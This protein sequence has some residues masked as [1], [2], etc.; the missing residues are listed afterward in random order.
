MEELQSVVSNVSGINL[1]EKLAEYTQSDWRILQPAWDWMRSHEHYV[2][3]PLF[4]VIMSVTYY[5]LCMLPWSIIDLY[6]Q[7]WWWIQKY[8]IQHHK[9]VTFKQVRNAMA[10]ILFN[11][12][13]F[14]LPLAVSQWVYVTPNK[15]PV[16]APAVWTI[17]WQCLASLAIFDIEYFLLH[18]AFHKIRFL[19][20][21]VHS[22]HH[23]Y[24]APS[25]WVTQYLHPFELI[26][27]GFFSTTAPWIVGVHP[28]TENL[29]QL[30][31][32]TVSVDSHIGYDLP[33]M[34]QH[35]FP[36]WAGCPHHDMHH[37]KPPTNFSPFFTYWDKLMGS[38]CPGR[39]GQGHKSKELQAWEH[40]DKE[41][42]WRARQKDLDTDQ[43]NKLKQN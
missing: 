15:L 4:P 13:V 10:L 40:S 22:V 24:S 32:I 21:H 1:T 27:V 38:F 42:R 39:G 37:E 8:K 16:M 33:F 36:F 26:S 30:L 9:Q 2:S 17:I 7:N 20:R 41:R 3:S 18:S 29:F 11:Q 34:P 19:Y 12:V 43:I 23:R 25:C 6:G 31:A 5:F 28:L 14:I 35:W